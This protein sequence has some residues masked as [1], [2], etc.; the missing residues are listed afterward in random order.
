MYLY[1]FCDL[2]HVITCYLWFICNLF[3]YDILRFADQPWLYQL[4]EIIML[5]SLEENLG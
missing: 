3:F 1:M 4:I 5:L 2:Y